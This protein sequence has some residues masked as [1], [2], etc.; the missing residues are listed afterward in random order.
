MSEQ[1]LDSVKA[2]YGAI[3]KVSFRAI[4]P[5]SAQWRRRSATQLRN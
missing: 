5:G 3:A 1:L 2:R 4:T